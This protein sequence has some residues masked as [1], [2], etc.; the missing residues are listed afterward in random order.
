MNTVMLPS[1]KSRVPG[2]QY[3]MMLPR[4]GFTILFFD[5]R[6]RC[7]TILI[8]NFLITGKNYLCLETYIFY[9]IVVFF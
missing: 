5:S 4:L 7:L 3:N 9:F 6:K 2:H 8:C 1:N